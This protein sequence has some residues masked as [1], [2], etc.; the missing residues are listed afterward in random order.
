[1]QPSLIPLD[2]FAR[3]DLVRNNAVIHAKNDVL[4]VRPELEGRVVD[5]EGLTAGITEDFMKQSGKPDAVHFIPAVYEAWANLI[6]SELM[7]E[8]PM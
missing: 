2:R 7:L 1:M 3:Q 8:G 5:A 4:R 6:W